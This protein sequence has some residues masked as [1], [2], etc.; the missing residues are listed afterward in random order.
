MG[1]GPACTVVDAMLPKNKDADP[2][3]MPASA[4]EGTVADPL[5][6][7]NTHET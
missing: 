4:A 2:G 5:A 6:A 7:G 1:N 3:G